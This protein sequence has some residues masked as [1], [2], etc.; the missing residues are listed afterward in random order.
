MTR[1]FIFLLMFTIVHTA[2]GGVALAQS[3][4]VW[5]FNAMAAQSAGIPILRD[6]HVS[7]HGTVRFK[8]NRTGNITLICPITDDLDG[9]S[10]RSLRLTYRDGDGRQGPSLVS[11]VIRR[12]RRSDGHIAT[13]PNGKVSSNDANAPNSGPTGWKTHQSGSP[14]NVLS[15]VLDLTNFYYFV[16][17]NL[18]RTDGAAPLGV[19]GV[20]LI[21]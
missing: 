7:S 10:L 19:M 3:K 13:L 12:V 17:I 21:N 2:P 11:A 1:L 5:S 4:V 16:Q 20:H 6:L 8:D 18:K 9:A 15:H 14:S